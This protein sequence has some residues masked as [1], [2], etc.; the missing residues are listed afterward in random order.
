MEGSRLI[1]VGCS[2]LFYAWSLDGN[3]I[4][5]KHRTV[6][7]FLFVNYGKHYN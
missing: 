3:Q 6:P 4:P 5:D 2:C 7:P 1:G